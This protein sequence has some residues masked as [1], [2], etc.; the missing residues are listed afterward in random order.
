MAVAGK[1]KSKLIVGL[2]CIISAF[3]CIVAVFYF[4]G[5]TH[6]ASQEKIA[7][8][9][10][11][12]A[13]LTTGAAPSGTSSAKTGSVPMK[14]DDLLTEAQKIHG[15]TE[16]DRTEGLLWIDRKSDSYI[17]TLGALNGLQKGS[18]LSV[19]DGTQKMEVVNVDQP[20]D[21]ISY[22]NPPKLSSNLNNH[23]YR[24]VVEDR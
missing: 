9:E 18:Q 12:I 13:E 16:K 20:F 6:M 7:A 23:F 8:L 5:K 2:G 11:K 21:I 1:N 19:Y 24:V 14:L 15:V 22:V 4:M 17:V 3:C 10:A